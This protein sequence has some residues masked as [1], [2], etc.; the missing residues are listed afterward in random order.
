MNSYKLTKTNH[1]SYRL[2][3]INCHSG[4]QINNSYNSSSPINNHPSKMPQETFLSQDLHKFPK[5]IF[6]TKLSS[7]HNIPH[8]IIPPQPIVPAQPTPFPYTLPN[9]PSKL[10]QIPL[11]S[12]EYLQTVSPSNCPN[13]QEIHTKIPAELWR[14]SDWQ[15]LFHLDQEIYGLEPC[16][17]VLKVQ[18]E[19]KLRDCHP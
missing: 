10:T 2:I 7:Q 11:P 12:Q 16:S 17:F 3:N 4:S 19:H 9:L 5:I 15:P 1:N 14:L 6:P 18:P 13:S 8:S